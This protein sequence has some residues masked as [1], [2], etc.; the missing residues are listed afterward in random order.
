[1]DN[2]LLVGIS[3]IGSQ[4]DTATQR[5]NGEI[6]QLLDY[7]STYPAN[8]ILYRSSAMVLFVHSEAGLHNKIKGHRRAGAHIVLSKND[9]MP[10][11]SGPALTLAQ[12]ITFVMSSAS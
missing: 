4:Q 8:V 3:A 2:K 11:W 7:S 6:N 9:P 12:I 5:T 1:M 10:K